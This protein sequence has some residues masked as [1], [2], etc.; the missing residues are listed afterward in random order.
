M[1]WRMER[2]VECHV[3]RMSDVC[4]RCAALLESVSAVSEASLLTTHALCRKSVPLLLFLLFSFPSQAPA[5]A[6]LS[7]S[8]S[9]SLYPLL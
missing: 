9:F 5:A 2:G 8:L 1:E 6:P 3:W 4:V 7:C